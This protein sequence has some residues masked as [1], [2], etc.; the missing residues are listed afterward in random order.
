VPG[1][2]PQQT[3]EEDFT[4]PEAVAKRHKLVLALNYLEPPFPWKVVA[5]SPGLFNLND[6]PDLQDFTG[7]Q[8]HLN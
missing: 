2:D 3:A 1:L 5:F 8:I 7:R 6:L 4:S